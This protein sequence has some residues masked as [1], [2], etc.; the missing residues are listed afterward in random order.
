MNDAEESGDYQAVGVKCRDALIALGK[1]H[2]TAEWVGEV[3][4][5][6]RAADFKGWANLFTDRLT[7]G[8]RLR[9]YLKASVD[10]G[11]DRLA[12][13]Q[14]RRHPGRRRHRDRGNR[15]GHRHIRQTHPSA[16]AW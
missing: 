14:Q 9:S 10:L 8:G 4:N 16:R 7:E 3:D 15:S 6:P 12:T 5:P 1:E 13:A 2:A 11:S